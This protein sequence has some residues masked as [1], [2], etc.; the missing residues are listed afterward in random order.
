MIAK[1][2]KWLNLPKFHH[3]LVVMEK[4]RKNA[5]ACFIQRNRPCDR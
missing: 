3:G 2:L 1:L 4:E 5:I